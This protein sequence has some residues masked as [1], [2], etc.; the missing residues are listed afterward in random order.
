MPL[1]A[2]VILQKIFKKADLP[3]DFCFSADILQAKLVFTDKHNGEKNG[4]IV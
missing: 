1:I 3:F 2:K 4:S